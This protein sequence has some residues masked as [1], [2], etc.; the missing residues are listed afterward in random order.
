[1]KALEGHVLQ[2]ALELQ[3]ELL[4][5]TTSFNPQRPQDEGILDVPA[6]DWSLDARD[7][8][9]AINGLSNHAWFF[10]SPLQYWNCSAE[11]I[12]G[13]QD[14]ISTVNARSKQATSVNVTLRHSIVFSGKRF[15]DHRLVAADALVITLIHK[16]ASPVGEVWGSKALELANKASTSWRLYPFDGSPS[17]SLYE[18]RCQPLS[19]QD[20]VL[21]G[22]AYSLTAIYFLYTLSNIRA[23][24]SRLGLAVTV[25]GQLALSIVSSLTVC[26]ILKIDLSK[27]PREAYPLVI[28]ACGLENIFRLINALILSPANG[29]LAA[30]MGDALGQT[31]HIALAA[32]AQ[33][34]AI[35]WALS[36]IVSP[37]IGSFC[38]FVAIALSF[39]FFYLLTFFVAVLGIDVRRTELTEA[40]NKAAVR[41]PSPSRRAPG[42][43]WTD[44]LFSAEA[45]MS[46]RIA[47]TVV[48]IGFVIVA[49]WHFL[50]NV[51]LTESIRHLALKSVDPPPAS[52]LIVDINQARTPT[53]WLRMQD[54]ETAREVIQVIKPH[55]HSYI[56]RVYE[57]L[58]FVVNGSDRT[59]TSSGVRTYLPAAYDFVR[60]ELATFALTIVVVVAAIFLLTSY[61]LHDETLDESIDESK[62]KDKTLLSLKTYK[63]HKLDIFNLAASSQG[64]IASVGLDRCI[65]FWDTQTGMR[66]HIDEAED[67][68]LFPVLAIAFDEK[69][70][71]LAV[72]RADGM[73]RLWNIT[74]KTWGPNIEV[75]IKGCTPLA[76]FFSNNKCKNERLILIRQ[77][78]WLL[79]LGL[80]HHVRHDTQVC[81]SRLVEA[82][83]YSSNPAS[84]TLEG[85]IQLVT[86]SQSGCFH[87]VSQSESDW[88]SE[89][90]HPSNHEGNFHTLNIIPLPALNAFLA[91]QSNTIDLIDCST[92]KTIRT[93]ATPHLEAKTLK[94]HYFQRQVS[95]SDAIHLK[96]FT[97][98]YTRKDTRNC[99]IQ[100]YAP[101]QNGSPI[102][103]HNPNQPSHDAF[104]PWPD[105]CE[106]THSIDNP[107]DWQ[108]LQSGH[109]IGIRKCTPAPQEQRPQHI[110]YLST[111][112]RRRIRPPPCSTMPEAQPTC[113]FEIWTFFPSFVPSAQIEQATQPLTHP[114]EM[115]HLLLVSSVGPMVKVSTRS[116]AVALGNVVK[117]ITVSGGGFGCRDEGTGQTT[118][119]LGRKRKGVGTRKKR[120]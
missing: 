1:M 52:P 86:T 8:L 39:D 2:S 26:A 45:P 12:E 41:G 36:K 3:D 107:G 10:H 38:T 56:A 40:L 79:Q 55:A 109:I 70:E 105:V 6:E 61:L 106:D 116:I 7:R 28:L 89:G 19:L 20:D 24:K 82:N 30:R 94:C 27:I 102:R 67:Q 25:V 84:A 91:C 50:D 58:I 73:I 66:H 110:S 71:W 115:D 63:G 85:P 43:T 77:D 18:F 69:S 32:V 62:G 64:I 9:H 108:L 37:G 23:L 95:A 33:D 44:S 120:V 13:D 47:G 81:K 22:V 118:L 100:T 31:G 92:R 78:A 98:A 75:D 83:V 97:L 111:G 99:I 15:E 46:T 88:I 104:Y 34:L 59:P 74:T 29:S 17:S 5:S 53:A 93:F 51:S 11:A 117:L 14:I 103:F 72:L 90:F 119:G 101:S 4:G 80:Q 112:L 49:Q 16:L 57:P 35:L 48:M 87:I 21:L 113:P 96:S 54:H 76:F 68:N 42:N 114:S 65:Y 60:D